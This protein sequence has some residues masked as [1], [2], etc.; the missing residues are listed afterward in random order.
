VNV[1]N[2]VLAALVAAGALAAS[3]GSNAE[4]GD[5]AAL[6]CGVERWPVKTLSDRAARRVNFRP[7][8]STV[9]ALRRLQRPAR[10]PERRIRPVEFRTYRVRVRLVEAKLED[11]RDVHLVVADPRRAG[12][13]MIVELPDVACSGPNRSVKRATMRR[14]RRAFE[15]SCGPPSSSRFVPLRGTATIVG[16]AFFDRL[17]GQRGL[18]PN[19]IELHPLVRFASSNC[20]PV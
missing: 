6:T 1:R 12:A 18:A 7:R 17:H 19:G 8:R 5:S 9:S 15:R 11:D 13:T 10:V 3:A 16:V 14:A 20:Q 2:G 4:R